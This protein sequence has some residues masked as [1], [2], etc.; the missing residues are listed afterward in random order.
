M[1]TEETEE[2]ALSKLRYLARAYTCNIEDLDPNSIPY[3]LSEI[4]KKDGDESGNVILIQVIYAIY[5][6]ESVL[7]EQG[8]S[9]HRLNA[10]VPSGDDGF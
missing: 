7:F 4:I 5:D 10:L 3:E 9:V 1:K 8:P 6:T 2:V